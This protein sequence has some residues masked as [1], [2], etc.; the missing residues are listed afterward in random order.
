M[1]RETRPVGE[2]RGAWS[3]WREGLGARNQGEEQDGAHLGAAPGT[4]PGSAADTGVNIRTFRSTLVLYKSTCS[5]A[6]CSGR[7]VSARFSI[8][9][10]LHALSRS[11]QSVREIEEVR[12]QPLSSTRLN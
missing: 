12:V 1:A 2:T 5:L 10:S 4:R 7:F 6:L 9:I 8:F 3:L 11:Y